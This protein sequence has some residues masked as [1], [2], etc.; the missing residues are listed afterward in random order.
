MPKTCSVKGKSALLGEAEA[1]DPIGHVIGTA[2][3][4][5][6]H[7][8]EYGQWYTPMALFDHIAYKVL[9]RIQSSLRVP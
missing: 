8:T 5:R 2:A 6:Q 4:D 3:R 1:Y 7:S 9:S